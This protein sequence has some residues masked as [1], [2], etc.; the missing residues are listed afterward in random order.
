MHN[1][2][3]KDGEAFRHTR[4]L[5]AECNVKLW[6]VAVALDAAHS[7]GRDYDFAFWYEAGSFCAWPDSAR[8][9]E[10]FGPTAAGA[11]NE[12]IIT[13]VAGLLDV[14]I[15]EGLFIGGPPRGCTAN[16]SKQQVHCDGTSG[17][18]TSVAA[19]QRACRS[20]LG[21][22]SHARPTTRGTRAT[23]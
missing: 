11:T 3:N 4:A 22:S 9:G 10:M 5:Y 6:L 21:V 20:Q 13:Q 12:Q 19:V 23:R 18:R 16:F 15:S 14:Q 1:K 8:V 17:M 2:D 7:E